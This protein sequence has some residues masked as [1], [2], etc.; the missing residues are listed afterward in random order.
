M[1]WSDHDIGMLCGISVVLFLNGCVFFRLEFPCLWRWVCSGWRAMLCDVG[2]YL[3][4]R[5]RTKE[6]ADVVHRA[7]QEEIAR[8]RTR[9]TSWALCILRYAI[10]VFCVYF[11]VMVSML[12]PSGSMLGRQGRSL[13]Q[14]LTHLVLAVLVL[15]VSCLPK[16]IFTRHLDLWQSLFMLWGAI[17]MFASPNY[18][19]SLV[20]SHAVV[21]FVRILFTWA[22][23]K[24]IVSIAWNFLYLVLWTYLL[25]R[26]TEKMILLRTFEVTVFSLTVLLSI[27]GNSEMMVGA[28]NVVQAKMLSGEVAAMKRLLN[29]ACDVTAEL[30]DA[31]VIVEPVP[32]F[33]AMLTLDHSKRSA[34]GVT[35][36]QFMPD[37]EDRRRFEGM[38]QASDEEGETADLE[39]GALHATLRASG[40]TLLKVEIFYVPFSTIDSRGHYFVGIREFS[41]ARPACL[42]R[43]PGTRSLPS[44]GQVSQRAPVI[45]VRRPDN[46]ARAPQPRARRHRWLGPRNPLGTS[47]ASEC[48][49]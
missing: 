12:D 39:P 13:V 1:A 25:S 16:G 28:R 2:K 22:H 19:K 45:S 43:V 49:I 36:Q 38:L 35:L 32:R 29:L 23:P 41:D 27:A 17:Y 8:Q 42:V 7:V 40:G 4:G 11:L 6:E 20:F 30:D 21:G 9:K 47:Q 34:Q 37:K 48:G 33:M 10:L 18:W 31:L 44:K 14:D 26:G 24:P 5:L 3:M 46:R 15:L